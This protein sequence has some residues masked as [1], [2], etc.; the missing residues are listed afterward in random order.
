MKE[1]IELLMIRQSDQGIKG[2]F[3]YNLWA[4]SNLFIV[5]R[6]HTTVNFVDWMGASCGIFLF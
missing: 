3:L 1:I 4:W 5:P 6:V 2:S